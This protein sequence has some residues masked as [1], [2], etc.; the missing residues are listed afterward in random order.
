[1][2]RRIALLLVV[3]VGL[4]F[5]CSFPPDAE[6]N[7]DPIIT[8]TIDSPT[9]PAI[10]PDGQP[11]LAPQ[12]FDPTIHINQIGFQPEQF[13]Q[14]ILEGPTSAEQSFLLVDRENRI[15]FNSVLIPF[16][17]DEDSR[18]D[19]AQ[20]DFSEFNIPG[21]YRAVI[22]GRGESYP[23]VIARD[24]NLDVL[25]LA[26]RWFYLQR[27]GVELNDTI[28]GFSHGADHTSA[29]ILWD[30]D[31]KHPGETF[32]VSGGWWDAGDYG[33]YTSP[34]AVT[35]MSLI[36]AYRFNPQAFADGSLS[37]PESGN[38][39]PD[40]LD[41]IRWELEWLLKMQR[42]DGAF[43]HK[44]ATQDYTEAAPEA[45]DQPIYL[46]DV[47]S[48]A[49]AQAAGALA[50]ASLLYRQV[51]PNFAARLQTAAELAWEWL[52]AN[53]GRVPD[54]GFQNPDGNQGGNY[55]SSEDEVA[56]RLWAAGGLFHA[57]QAPEFADAFAELWMERLDWPRVYGLYWPDGYVFGM[58]AYL[59]TSGGQES[60][61]V[62]VR[63]VI[64]EQTRTLL[65]IVD[66][67]GY[68]LVLRGNEDEFGWTWGSH[69]VM[70][71][72][73]TYLLLANEI[74]PDPALVDG[75]AAQ[76]NWILGT[77]PLNKTFLSGVGEN[78]ILTLHHALS[79]LAGRAVPGALGEGP[80]AMSVGGDPILQ[81]LFDLDVPFSRRYADD[82]GSW[83]TNE[84]TIYGNA[85]FVA[86][87]AWF[88]R[89][90]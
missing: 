71:G 73:A 31:G 45:D 54:R 47:S 88:N 1:M 37:I 50:E 21:E 24:V 43:H 26:A 63:R 36:Y 10:S 22:E 83:A 67:T 70:L 34:A 90:P 4:A 58:F 2:S 16:G 85:A 40:L 27:S 8:S 7:P 75:A 6:P 56:L 29:A 55:S 51:D 53:P 12:S 89:A 15:V 81:A 44:A 84:P 59:D 32:D 68:R 17:F 28:S 48:Q 13:K 65:E 35:I 46:F 61:R 76:L 49:T 72:Y 30:S 25:H 78:P 20:G 38:G 18:I 5:A 87:A 64:D 42:P 82:P 86:V 11:I 69:A 19:V 60:I 52:V 62:D 39:V 80:N 41:E 74:S 57:T 77:N 23:F 14:V 9:E 79:I 33:R 66:N 3:L